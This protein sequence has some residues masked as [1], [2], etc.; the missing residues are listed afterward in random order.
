LSGIQLAQYYVHKIKELANNAKAKET[1]NPDVDEIS[2]LDKKIDKIERE[3]RRL[4]D[5]TL[6][7]ETGKDGFESLLSGKAKEQIKRKIIQHVKKHPNRKYS[8]F[9]TLARAIQFCDIDDLK[10]TI[11][12]P[13]YWQFFELRFQDKLKVEKY[14]DY[15]SELRN[16]IRHKRELTNLVVYKGKAAIEWLEM[17]INI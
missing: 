5:D 3:L 12:K 1:L 8:D 9:K 6:I 17:I 15:L 13:E 7:K 4:I 16:V 2:E 11:V 14:F 10:K